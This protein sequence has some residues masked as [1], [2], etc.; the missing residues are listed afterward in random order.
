MHTNLFDHININPRNVHIPDGSVERDLEQYCSSYEDAIQKAGGLDLQILGIGRHGHIGFNEPASSLRSRTRIK[1]L[2]DKT[3]EDNRRFFTA[4]EVVPEAAIT[5]GVGT[6]LEAKR[7][8]LLASGGHK[9][10]AIARAIE[11]PMSASASASALQLHSDVTVIVDE[12]AAH[13]LQEKNYYRRVVEL[14]AK[15]TPDKLW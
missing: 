12:D 5:V 10:N 4:D 7:I 8:L 9:A 11:G 13:E 2:S 1:T 6:I 15:Y 3:R 14:T